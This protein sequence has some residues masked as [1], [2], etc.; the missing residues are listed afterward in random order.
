MFSSSSYDYESD[1]DGNN[2]D[3]SDVG[4]SKT[5]INPRAQ[6]AQGKITSFF[7]GGQNEGNSMHSNATNVTQT[8]LPVCQ[9]KRKTV[10]NFHV[11]LA[12]ANNPTLKN[13]KKAI[14]S[15]GNLHQLK[16]HYKRH[17]CKK[18][19]NCD[20][21]SKSDFKDIVNIDHASVPSRIRQLAMGSGNENTKSK[22][23]S[24]TVCG[25]RSSE[26][27]VETS[28]NEAN[29][30]TGSICDSA[31]ST[32]LAQTVNT[33][34]QLSDVEMEYGSDTFADNEM[35]KESTH[36]NLLSVPSSLAPVT[37]R[38][39]CNVETTSRGFLQTDIGNFFQVPTKDVQTKIL[40]EMEKLSRKIDKLTNNQKT[41]APF[42]AVTTHVQDSEMSQS[43]KN[44][45]EWREVSN[46][47]ELVNA[48]EHLALYPMNAGEFEDF[49]QGGAILRCETCFMLH[50][51]TARRLTPA[52]A[53]KKL[54]TDCKSICTGKYIQP[55][56]MADLMA[57]KGEKWRK[58]KNRVL[59]HMTCS[60][61]GQTHFKALTML[62]E[63]KKLKKIQCDAAQTL[64]KCAFTA[65]KSKSAAL[66]YESQ[67]AFAYS[68]GAQV[69]STGHSRKMFSD[70]IKC[71]LSVINQKTREVMTTCLPSTGMPPHYYMT[72]DK[73]TVNKRTNQAVI[74]CPMIEGR[75]IPIAVA[76]PLV[77]SPDGNSGVTGGSAEDS[78]I[79]ALNILRNKYGTQVQSFM[80]GR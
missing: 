20:M 14:L 16:R 7:H 13:K 8:K 47:I 3:T 70:L 17:H 74:V 55:S 66:H 4:L 24:T 72:L 53:A 64:I 22:V 12:C 50:R 51:E 21:K 65:L 39:S 43:Y 23:S 59:Q 34:I 11:C 42:P 41:G 79:Q 1:R 80:I 27:D 73:A 58:L 48:V 78:G 76:A 44:M 30:Q 56:L 57:G 60:T 75:R 40:E 5:P 52:R 6:P 67:V 69:G 25:S 15:R 26:K 68:V 10:R 31:Q 71:M 18:G 9:K 29:N 46:L 33:N 28:I 61:D 49:E 36:P 62:A 45:L 19:A 63:D 38:E 35:P 54:A 32:T 77:Y 2:S 37:E